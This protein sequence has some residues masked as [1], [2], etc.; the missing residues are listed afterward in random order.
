MRVELLSGNTYRFFCDFYNFAGALADPSLIKFKIYDAKYQLES[1]VSVNMVSN[2]IRTGKYFYDYIIP[3]EDLDKK[4]YFEFYGE[5]EGKPSIY[6]DEF[7]VKFIK[8]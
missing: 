6:R 8:K 7:I 1:E 2:K 4:F 3:T 5:L